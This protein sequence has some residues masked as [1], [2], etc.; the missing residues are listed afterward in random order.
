MT[1][2]LDTVKAEASCKKLLRAT[3]GWK[4]FHI[5]REW[6]LFRGQIIRIGSRE[7]TRPVRDENK[8]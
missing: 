2:I 1:E 4:D 8:N 6:Y 3:I 7:T 5:M